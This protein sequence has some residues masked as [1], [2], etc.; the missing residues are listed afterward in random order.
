MKINI[1]GTNYILNVEQAKRGGYLSAIPDY[2]LRGGDVYVD[3]T[4]NINP[5]LLVGVTYEPMFADKNAA[6]FQLL[7]LGGSTNNGDFYDTVHNRE[8]IAEYLA[9]NKMVFTRNISNDISS[10]VSAAKR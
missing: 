8:E 1:K 5:F 6:K 2:P 4:G 10:L 3:P 7:G 9:T